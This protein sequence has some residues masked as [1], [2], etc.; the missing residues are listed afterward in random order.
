MPYYRPSTATTAGGPFTEFGVPR[1]TF[2]GFVNRDFQKTKQ[3]FGTLAAEY[4][5][6]D[7]VTLNSKFR[8]ERAI[9][10]YI[11]TLAES[12]VITNPNPACGR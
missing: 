1:G 10:N 12:P 2:Y 6:N 9:L 5:I 3:D 11:G 8:A 4:D 7:W